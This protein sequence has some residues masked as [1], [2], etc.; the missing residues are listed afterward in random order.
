MGSI[1]PTKFGGEVVQ[2]NIPEILE[3]GH[4][5]NFAPKILEA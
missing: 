5:R 4:L 3:G 1:K 2:T